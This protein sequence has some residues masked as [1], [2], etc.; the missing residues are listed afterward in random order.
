MTTNE[1]NIIDGGYKSIDVENPR[2]RYQEPFVVTTWIPNHRNGHYVNRVALKH[3][4]FKKDVDPNVHVKVFNYIV[5][6]NAKTFEENII[7]AF[8]YTLKDTISN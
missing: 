2:G 3:P 1:F 8:S 6:A 5:K 7:N 4:D